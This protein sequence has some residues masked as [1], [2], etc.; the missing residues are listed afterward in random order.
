MLIMLTLGA[1]GVY[2]LLNILKNL[3]PGRAKIQSDLAIMKAELQ[4]LVSDLVP[5]SKE[6]MEQLSL[7]QINRK[8]N[9]GVATTIK[10][11]FTTI[12]HEPVIAWAYKKYVSP[13]ENALVYARTTAHEFIFRIKNGE[14]EIVANNKLM[15][16]LDANGVLRPAKGVKLLAQINRQTEALMLPV[17]VNGKQVGSLTN[18]EKSGQTNPRAFQMIAPM[19]Q[20]EEEV[21]LSLG[22]LEMVKRGI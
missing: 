21:F 7:N 20:E 13:K 9:R 19:G 10:G 16:T 4:P 1:A 5:W 22:V 18:P 12:Y 11:V 14:V 2:L 8:A 3:K 17:Q 15:G 6:E